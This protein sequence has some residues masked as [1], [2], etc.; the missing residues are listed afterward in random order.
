MFVI[1][2]GSEVVIYR[3]IPGVRGPGEEEDD[4]K[5]WTLVRQGVVYRS[6]DHPGGECNMVKFM[7]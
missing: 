3:C 6:D 7:G 4:V 5:P 1:G 2:L